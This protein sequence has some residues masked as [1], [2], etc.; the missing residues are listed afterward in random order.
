MLARL[1][2]FRGTT[3]A[4]IVLVCALDCPRAV[5]LQAS[6][7]PPDL[8][9]VSTAERKMI[10]F[11]CHVDRQKNDPSVYYPCLREQVDALHASPGRPDLRKLSRAERHMI[12]SACRPDRQISGPAAYYRC[13]GEQLDA[14]HASQGRPDLSTLSRAE[15][16]MIV[17]ACRVDGRM[18]GPAAYYRCLRQ[19]VDAV[20]TQHPSD[21]IT[22]SS[23]NDS[24]FSSNSQTGVAKTASPPVPPAAG[25]ASGPSA[26]SFSYG[27]LIVWLVGL[28][29]VGSLAKVVYHQINPKKCGRC[30]TPTQTRGGY[31]PA[32]VAVME[33][34]ATRASEQEAAE[35]RARA[36]AERYEREQWEPEESRRVTELAELQRL[37]EPEFYD[38]IASLFRKD[39][40]T[41]R[42][43]GG[44][45][46]EGI[47]LLLQMGQDK[48]VVQCKSSQSEIGAPIV[49]EFYGALMHAAACHGFLVTTA[50]FNQSARDFAQGKPM[51]L[52]S[53]TEVLAWMNSTYSSRDQRALL[54]KNQ[55]TLFD[56]YAVLGV[57]P[58]ASLDEIR[59]AYRREMVNYHPDKV[60]HLGKDLQEFA[61]TK[62]QEINR[63][64]EELAHSQ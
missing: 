26:S 36:E 59:A 55:P 57:S 22:G 38:L 9:T 20:S 1:K 23:K 37:A 53:G 28:L 42:R 6:Q 49:R 14:L 3:L 31:C 16:R 32:C 18:N 11:A 7:G 47:D 2:R 45:G 10:E 51:S 48:D 5:A 61:K 29:V 13:S 50:S 8:S 24:G 39:G 54:P 15:Q 46:D 52:I 21:R 33:E 63:A 19:K 60:A 62:T 64:Y 34:S 27:R 40:Y 56:P 58:N 12:E 4:I 30:G 35:E 25:R 41:V 43:C 17:S 44:N